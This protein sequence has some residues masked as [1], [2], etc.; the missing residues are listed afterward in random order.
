[1]R[2]SREKFAENRQKILDV[3]GVMFREHGFD[4]V[5]VADIMKAC[6]LTHGGFYGHFQS[7]DDLQLEVSRALIARVET[8]WKTLIAEAPDRPLEALL[9]HYVSWCAVDDPGNSC[10]FVSLME[11]VSRSSGSVRDR[12][13]RYAGR[14]P[15][16]RVHDAVLDDGGRQPR[17]RRRKPGAG[18]SVSVDDAGKA[19]AS[20][21]IERLRTGMFDLAV[22][23]V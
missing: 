1:M 20:A 3:A 17:P 8:R 19:C 4:G 10:V 6:G 7:K 15:Q 23:G 11:E 12:A 18:R 13:R 22:A 5:G 9:N 14:A 2:V 16:E 21:H